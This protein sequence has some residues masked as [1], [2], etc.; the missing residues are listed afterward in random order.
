MDVV[1]ILIEAYLLVGI[2]VATAIDASSLG[3][4]GRAGA[5]YCGFIIALFWPVSLIV[6]WCSETKS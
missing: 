6:S 5:I 2:F 1:H 3:T 4:D